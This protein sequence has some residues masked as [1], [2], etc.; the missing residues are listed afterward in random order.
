M[1]GKQSNKQT[2]DLIVIGG[3][4]AGIQAALTARQAGLTVAIFEDGTFGGDSLNYSDLPLS[5]LQQSAKLY[6]QIQQ[7]SEFYGLHNRFASFNYPKIN[8]NAKYLIR[9]AYASNRD[10]CQSR[11]I[12]IIDQRAYFLTPNQISA[13]GRHYTAKHFI[14]ATGASWQLPKIAGLDEVDYHTPRDFLAIDT[15]P[16]SIFIIG[17]QPVALELAQLLAIFGVQVYF[18]SQHAD[19]L[20]SFDQEL[21]QFIEKT[22]NNDFKINI[23]TS[24]RL[25]EVSQTRLTKNLT[26]IH[27]GIERQLQTDEL[28]IAENITPN[29]DLG[30]SNAVVNYN[31]KI[32]VND[33]LQSSNQRIWAVGDAIGVRNLAHSAE[34]EAETAVRNI[35]RARQQPVNY[36]GLMEVVSLINPAIKIGQSEDDCKQIGLKCRATTTTYDELPRQIITPPAQGILKLVVNSE[37]QLIGAQ[38]FGPD[39]EHI[40]QQLSLAIRNHFT[41]N[42]LLE[43]PQVYLSWQ[44]IIN[45]TA[46]KLI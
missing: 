10:F 37:R 38:I 26:L 32:I 16:K 19:L 31:D 12:E 35:V 36:Q 33:K 3:G 34:I 14:I 25:A 11:G 7:Q 27:A 43:L 24:S 23:S 41:I 30:L 44:E 22:L 42:Q 18:C 17:G 6:H 9:N 21:S 28:L 4:S 46:N 1:V 20:P 5:F 13:D 45:F 8:T 40:A 2:F 29:L 39:S 15:L